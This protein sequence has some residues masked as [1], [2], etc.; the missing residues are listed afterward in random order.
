[1]ELREWL[2]ILGLALVT[3]IVIDGVRRLK[4]QRRV[5]RLDQAGGN[6]NHVDSQAEADD[7]DNWELPNGGAR[8]VRP[9]SY[10]EVKSKPKLERQEHPGPSRVLSG[11]REAPGD[12]KAGTPNLAYPAASATDASRPVA[13][14]I[15][16]SDTAASEARSSEA[17]T[18]SERAPQPEVSAQ[19][20]VSIKRAE[21]ELDLGQAERVQV[22]QQEPSVAPTPSRAEEAPAA[23]S[24][25]KAPVSEPAD[26]ESQASQAQASQPQASETVAAKPTVVERPT[27]EESEE[28]REPTLS[29]LDDDEPVLESA[30]VS[31]ESEPLAADPD[32]H[33]LHH[34]EDERYRLVDLE[35]MGNSIKSGSRRVGESM[36]RFGVSMQQR[37]AKRREQ[38][39]EERARRE[40][41]RAEK[42]AREAQQRRE[43]AEAQAAREAELRRLEAEAIELAD[44]DDPLFAPPR[45]RGERH[46]EATYA[47]PADY[48]E[49]YAEPAHYAERAEPSLS[50]DAI[51]DDDDVVRAHPTLARALRHN[52]N[53]ERARE[54]LSHADEIIVI[55]VLSRD[56]EGFS[57]EALLNLMLACGLRYSSDMGIFHRFETEDPDSELQFSMVNVLKPGTFPI[58]A[59]DEFRT[60]GITLLMPLPGALDTA[61]AFEA[62]VETA[63]VIVRNL[64]GEL[65]DE[66]HSVMT[67]QTV[68]FARQRVQEFE[69]R[70]RLNRYQ[71]N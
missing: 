34:D 8:V 17:Q 53:A 24:A 67:A 25:A 66:N 9:A 55:S 5:P 70:N 28:R 41:E 10:S 65:K 32:D 12:A 38:K 44:D 45:A 14:A 19:P 7:D 13:S 61:A 2:I 50:S 1:M 30:S 68:E 48:A 46:V 27:V 22:Q 16:A 49:P 6:N 63:M 64:G 20:E 42:A 23:A 33:D 35:G 40:Q 51:N 62:M 15:R 36:H 56:E 31:A 54:T 71:V 47:A 59:M 52:V 18:A 21:P 29:A 26:A 69:R 43:A 57:G 60:P 4:R 37:L 39:R 58:E 3:L 11:F